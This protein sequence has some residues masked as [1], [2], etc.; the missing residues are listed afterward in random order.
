[1]A[2]ADYEIALAT[3]DDIAGILDLQEQNLPEQGGVLSVRLPFEW[4]ETALAD[5]PLIVTR[6][7]GRVVGYLVASSVSSQAHL[8]VVQAMLRVY[9]GSH[10]YGPICIAESERGRGLAAELFAAQRVQLGGRECVTFIR[11]DNARSLR[12]HAKMGM[13]EVAEFTHGDNVLVVVAYTG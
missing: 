8:P 3:R 6:R 12:A 11:H 1:M 9:P 2:S 5:L 4:F 7:A 10:I 13:R